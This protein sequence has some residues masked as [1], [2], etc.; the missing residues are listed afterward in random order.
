MIRHPNARH[1]IAVAIGVRLRQAREAK[2]FELTHVALET[3]VS[4]RSLQLIENGTTL[5]RTTTL[6]KIAPVLEVDLDW[7]ELGTGKGPSLGA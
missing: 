4:Y 5:A 3:K 2:R 7:L 1:P 6:E